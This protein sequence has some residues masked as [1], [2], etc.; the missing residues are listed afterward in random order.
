MHANELA[1]DSE[2]GHCFEKGIHSL[3]SLFFPRDPNDLTGGSRT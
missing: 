1:S 2:T 3:L